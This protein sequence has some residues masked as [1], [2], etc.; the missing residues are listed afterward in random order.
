MRKERKSTSMQKSTT[1]NVIEYRK[2]R[3]ERT[4]EPI[5]DDRSVQVLGYAEASSSL[6]VI[7]CRSD[8]KKQRYVAAMLTPDRRQDRSSD[9]QQ[10][11]QHRSGRRRPHIRPVAC[12][13][14]PLLLEMAF[15]VIRKRNWRSMQPAGPP[16]FVD[17][18]QLQPAGG[19]EEASS[20]HR[21]LT[22]V[23]QCKRPGGPCT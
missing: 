9:I 14:G 10:D 23:R 20:V 21:P 17:P 15:A 16:A 19:G 5:H 13:R 2:R 3:I 11:D 4:N 12:R 22:S 18:E 1:T 7:W 6:R 8:R